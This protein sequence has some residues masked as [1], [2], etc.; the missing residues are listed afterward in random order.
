MDALSYLRVGVFT[1]NMTGNTVILGLALVG[2]GRSHVYDCLLALGAFAAGA[3]I[4]GLV[5]VR[6][7]AIADWSHD[8]TAGVGLELP[9]VMAFSLLWWIFPAHGPF[10]A[11]A[12]LTS[13]AACALGM[14]SV[15]VRRLKISG[16]S[17]TFITGT[18]TTAIIASLE[19]SDPEAKSKEEVHN[20]P[21]LLAGML[22]IY[23]I[24]AATGGALAVSRNPLAAPSAFVPLILVFLRS[25]HQSRP[26]D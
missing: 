15:A 13:T 14:Q 20:S 24:A 26:T 7:R 6:R 2:P 10:A 11:T 9:F 22:A 5:L 18:I 23:G 21:P 8:L 1:A 12:A 3:L 19:K 17:T 25:L 16:V 4:A